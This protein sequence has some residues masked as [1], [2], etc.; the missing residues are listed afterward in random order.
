MNK[1]NIHIII[2]EDDYVSMLDIELLLNELGYNNLTTV[3]NYEEANELI[4]H[5]GCDLAIVDIVLNGKD[6][7]ILLGNQLHTQNIPFF[8]LSSF[9]D[10][11]IYNKAKK[12]IPF[13][14][15]NKPIDK[16]TLDINIELA[17]L[18]AGKNKADA[19]EE[20]N[21][22]EQVLSEGFLFLKRNKERKKIYFNEIIYIKTSGNYSIFQ[23]K[24]KR[25]IERKSL[26]SVLKILP[27]SNFI[28]INKS[29][30]IQIA[31]IEKINTTANSVFIPDIELP[32]GR[33]YKKAFF[34]QLGID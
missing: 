28:Q 4:S 12:A 8:Y 20:V 6:Q 22:K 18:N 30:V 13:A 27:S 23:T 26:K 9:Q 32:I 2:V 31:L 19:K 21:L 10:E 25:F 5:S 34:E 29:T 14:F 3:D 33:K 7:G 17:L 16:R 15:L 1:N 24:D 11:S